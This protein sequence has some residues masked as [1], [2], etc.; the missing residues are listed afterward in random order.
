M[1]NSFHDEPIQV[2]IFD[3]SAKEWVGAIEEVGLKVATDQC[4]SSCE[5]L[6][7]YVNEPVYAW[8][9][10]SFVAAFPSTQIFINYGISFPQVHISEQKTSLNT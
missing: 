8:K 3:G 9:N 2:P 1:T 7:A 10:D 4:G 6:M 5:K